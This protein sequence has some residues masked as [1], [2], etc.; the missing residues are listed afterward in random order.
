MLGVNSR[1]INDM[2]LSIGIY[3]VNPTPGLNVDPH[4]P[5]ILAFGG[6]V[7][8]PLVTENPLSPVALLPGGFSHVFGILADNTFG[9]TIYPAIHL[10]THIFTGISSYIVGKLGEL[11]CALVLQ[12]QAIQMMGTGELPTVVLENPSRLID[13]LG[14]SFARSLDHP[15]EVLHGVKGFLIVPIGN[16][17]KTTFARKLI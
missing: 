11:R 3:E 12:F 1:L 14:I 9:L 8:A 5:G 13:V 10:R 17:I 6:L 4:L 7:D 16:V 15:L 2:L